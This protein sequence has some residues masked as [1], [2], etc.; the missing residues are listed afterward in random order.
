[1]AVK[2]KIVANKSKEIFFILLVFFLFALLT[3]SAHAASVVCA[4]G[5]LCVSGADVVCFVKVLFIVCVLLSD[6]P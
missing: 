2:L 6:L 4:I 3:F 5:A 1:M